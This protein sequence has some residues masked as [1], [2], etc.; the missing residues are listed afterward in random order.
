MDLVVGIVEAEP[1]FPSWVAVSKGLY[2]S[3]PQLPVCR[4]GTTTLLGHQDIVSELAHQWLSLKTPPS[5]TC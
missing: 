1:T 5:H 4:A 2:F 3:E